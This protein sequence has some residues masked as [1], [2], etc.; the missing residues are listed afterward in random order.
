MYCSTK[1]SLLPQNVFQVLTIGI[2]V[3]MQKA[4]TAAS[5][6]EIQYEES[7]IGFLWSTYQKCGAPPVN[8]VHVL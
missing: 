2:P 3:K 8:H 4:V 6:P 1:L 7:S 5:I